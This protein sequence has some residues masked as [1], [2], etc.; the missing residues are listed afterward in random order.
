[1][2][3]ASFLLGIDQG[4]SGSRALILDQEGNA[5]GYGYRPLPRIYPHPDW[6]EQDPLQVVSTVSESIAEACLRANISPADIAACGIA[7]QRNTEFVWD[8]QTSRAFSNAI[9]WQDLRTTP[10][11][12]EM[13]HW[14]HAHA[15]RHHL[16]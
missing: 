2:S 8:A 6:V 7:C 9:S 12:R 13:E 1:M 3:T 16:G 14:Q 4:T 11:V 10:L 5:R 15:A